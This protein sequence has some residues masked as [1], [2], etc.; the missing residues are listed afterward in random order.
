V[1]KKKPKKAPAQPTGTHGNTP[2]ASPPPPARDAQGR[3]LPGHSGNPAGR[4]GGTKGFA[5]LIR[6]QSGDGEELVRIAFQTL[7][8]ELQRREWMGA[9]EGPV[10]VVTTPSVKESLD[11]L[12]WLADRGWGKAVETVELSGPDGQPL[13]SETTVKHE[14]PS[15]QRLASVL[16]VLARAGFIPPAGAP[17]LPAQPADAADNQVHPAGG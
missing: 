9:S 12:K 15:P 13:Q 7:R 2:A 5:A 14:A 3:L 4:P 6:E 10:Q 17:G 1:A 16:G 11:A 8:G